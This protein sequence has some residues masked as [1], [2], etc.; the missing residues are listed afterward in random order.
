M[1]LLDTN[2]ISELM[3]DKP[4]LVVREWLAKQSAASLHTTAIAAAEIGQGLALLP[5]GKRRQQLQTA[6]DQLFEQIFRG[7]V[8]PFNHR[9]AR[10]FGPL[11]AQRKKQARPIS[12]GDAATAAIALELS[13]TIA[14]RDVGGFA[15]LGLEIVNPWEA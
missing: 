10:H 13:A 12:F 8:H 4:D 15:G 3:R 11:V 1:I 6:A 2:V 5:S 9:S 14:T 7:R